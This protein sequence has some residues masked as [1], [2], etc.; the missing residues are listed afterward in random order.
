MKIRLADLNDIEK[1]VAFKLE[2]LFHG[3]LRDPANAWLAGIYKRILKSRLL[4]QISGGT[5]FFLACNAQ[6]IIAYISYIVQNQ[7]AVIH[8]ISASEHCLNASCLGKL[9]NNAVKK[10]SRHQCSQILARLPRD[11]KE[12]ISI[13]K[14]HGFTRSGSDDGE[15]VLMQVI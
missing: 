12:Y 6:K 3:D 5:E 15:V 14:K 1:L 11:Y 13:F 2:N 7:Q 8:D 9:I 4:R 10:I